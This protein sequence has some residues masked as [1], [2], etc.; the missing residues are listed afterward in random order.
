[1]ADRPVDVF[2][3]GL[4][5]DADLLRDEYGVAPVNPRRAFVDGFELRIG[6]RSTLVPRPAARA[7]GTVVALSHPELERLYS[8]PGLEPYRPEAVLARPLDGEPVP[9][10]CY[11]LPEAPPPDE[12]NPE[13]AERLARA[14][15][16]L[17]FPQEYVAYVVSAA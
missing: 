9:A 15:R 2:F 12:R 16:K 17:D 4:F 7:Y 10:L 14:L 8:G 5:M 6:R 1:M 11:C 3:Y 13:Y